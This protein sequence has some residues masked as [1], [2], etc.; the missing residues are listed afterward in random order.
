MNKKL[1]VLFIFSIFV[2]KNVSSMEKIP[3]LIIGPYA[4]VLHS[5]EKRG[6]S[7]YVSY[8]IY[9][10]QTRVP[11]IV[12]K[13]PINIFI[14]F[15]FTENTASKTVQ[16]FIKKT[17]LGSFLPNVTNLF[18]HTHLS[19][20]PIP[21]LISIALSAYLRKNLFQPTICVNCST[22]IYSDENAIMLRCMHAVHKKCYAK[23]CLEKKCRVCDQTP[24]DDFW[25]ELEEI[26]QGAS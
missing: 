12:V 10:T 5:T 2:A 8:Q 9:N 24:E 17:T 1:C 25:F 4:C 11:E 21:K 22:K 3:N 26:P 16:C 6:S 13:N 19:D 14:I 20:L 23:H 7:T 18:P 15:S